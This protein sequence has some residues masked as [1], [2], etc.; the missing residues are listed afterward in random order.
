MPAIDYC[1]FSGMRVADC[2]HCR[3]GLRALPPVVAE[4]L[5]EEEGLPPYLGGSASVM[6]GRPFH[7]QFPGACAACPRP[8][9]PGELIK[10][11]GVGGWVHDDC[12]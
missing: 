12:E 11:D 7:A 5:P 10:A 3:R 8:V 6:P 9:V 4:A 2:A 1:E